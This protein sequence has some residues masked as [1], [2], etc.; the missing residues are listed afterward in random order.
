MI[1]NTHHFFGIFNSFP[2][3]NAPSV[4]LT[5]CIIYLKLPHSHITLVLHLKIF[6]VPKFKSQFPEKTSCSLNEM[7]DPWKTIGLVCMHLGWKWTREKL[8]VVC[9]SLPFLRFNLFFFDGMQN[10]GLGFTLCRHHS[11]QCF[12]KFFVYLL[13]KLSHPEAKWICYSCYF[14]RW[15][16]K[17]TFVFSSSLN[18]KSWWNK[19]GN[20]TSAQL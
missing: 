20:L 7:R 10:P 9:F 6:F 11:N 14:L 4:S 18:E 19:K 13:Q 17:A 1:Y 2:K 16:L 5:P 8:Q 15:F 3:P 12:I